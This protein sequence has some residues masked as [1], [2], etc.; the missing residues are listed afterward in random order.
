[1]NLSYSLGKNRTAVLHRL[2]GGL[3]L[4]SSSFTFTLSAFL[5]WRSPPP[6]VPLGNAELHT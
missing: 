1:M 5:D 3:L 6:S 2:S 4:P